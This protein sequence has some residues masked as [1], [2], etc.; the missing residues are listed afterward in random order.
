MEW[1]DFLKPVECRCGRTHLSTI[2]HILVEDGAVLKLPEILKGYSYENICIISDI[3]TELAA[4]KTVGSILSDTGY[5]FKKIIIQDNALIPDEYAIGTIMSQIDRHCG[6]IIA[7]GSGTINDLCKFIACQLNVDY[8]VIATAPSMDGYASSVA[9]LIVKHMKTPYEVRLPKVIVADVKILCEA[10]ME[11]IYAGFGDILGRY[12]SLADW[13][14]AHSILG[15]YRCPYVERLVKDSTET[16]VSSVSGLKEREP[17]AVKA[18]MEA[19]ILSGVAMNYVGSSRPASGSEH[20]LSHF[21]EMMFH[22][23]GETGPLHGTG[24]GVGTVVML[25]MCE[26]FRE[27]KLEIRAMRKQLSFDQNIW[28]DAV[29]RIYGQA[30]PEAISLE[31]R[32]HKNSVESMDARLE[33]LKKKYNGIMKMMESLPS[34]DWAAGLL[35]DLG[36]PYKPSMIGVSDDILKNSIVYAKELRNCFGFL[37]ILFDTGLNYEYG[38]ALVLWDRSK[39]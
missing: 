15:E 39:V 31:N 17:K 37:Q 27:E 30:A 8:F 35:R 26:L 24:V 33:N 13:K 34:S 3:H 22:F 19:L 25:K 7:V 4:G 9:Q 23:H 32:V 38:K 2:E 14:M 12:F 16:V 10:P 6:L 21:W 18:L 5:E 29:K 11:M 20:Q 28:E 36:A 1:K